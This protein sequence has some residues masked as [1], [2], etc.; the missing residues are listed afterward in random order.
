MIL[1]FA[2]DC[3]VTVFDTVDQ[4]NSGCEGIDVE[5][6]VY[7][8]TNEHSEILRPVF[9]VPNSKS[10]WFIGP[11]Y[12]VKSG[13]FMLERTGEHNLRLLQDTLAGRITVEHGPTGIRTNE[14]LKEALEHVAP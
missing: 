9:T 1:A 5:E 12:T 10:K 13:I 2:N 3:T 7:L 11:L 4:A 8:F 14:Q 6:G